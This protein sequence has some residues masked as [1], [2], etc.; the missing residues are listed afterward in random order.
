MTIKGPETVCGAE[1][2]PGR[3]VKGHGQGSLD[4]DDGSLGTNG[5][6]KVM[7]KVPRLVVGREGPG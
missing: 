2:R 1:D 4:N 7:Q 3:L 6:L 5:L